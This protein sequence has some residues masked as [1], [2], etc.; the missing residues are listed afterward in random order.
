MNSQYHQ[1]QLR[2]E[3]IFKLTY[4]FQITENNLRNGNVRIEVIAVTLQG[5]L[6]EVLLF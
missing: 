5:S 2:K 3:I 4:Q 6:F 1:R